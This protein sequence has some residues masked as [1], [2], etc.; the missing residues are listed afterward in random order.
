MLTKKAAALKYEKESDRAPVVV[1]KGKGLIAENIIAKAEESGIPLF[2]NELLADSLLNIDLDSKIPPVLYKAVAEVF[3]WLTTND[4]AAKTKKS[5][6]ES[7]R[8]IDGG[9]Q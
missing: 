6:F 1:A 3:I 7:A 8:P 9:I 2:K 5:L 4:S